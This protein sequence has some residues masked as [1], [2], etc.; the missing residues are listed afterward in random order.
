MAERR[1][2]SRYAPLVPKLRVAL[3]VASIPLTGC[4]SGPAAPEPPYANTR[5]PVETARAFLYSSTSCDR[6]DTGLSYDLSVAPS[7]SRSEWVR[8]ALLGCRDTP[9]PGGRVVEAELLSRM[10]DAARVRA[11]VIWPS[12]SS[13]GGVHQLVR[14]DH[15]W[16]LKD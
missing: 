13:I 7:V 5:G 15:G 9:P 3:A 6:E 8:L 2:R 14:T 12:G 4:G 11:R 1:Q 10:G 16:R